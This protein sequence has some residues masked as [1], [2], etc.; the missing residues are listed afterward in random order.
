MYL[1]NKHITEFWPEI[2]LIL[3]PSPGNVT[4]PIFFIKHCSLKLTGLGVMNLPFTNLML[5]NLVG[6][7][8]QLSHLDLEV[9]HTYILVS[10]T[11]IAKHIGAQSIEFLILF[12]NKSFCRA[13]W[14]LLRHLGQFFSLKTWFNCLCLEVFRSAIIDSWHSGPIYQK[15][16][17]FTSLTWIVDLKIFCQPGI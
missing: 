12:P 4:T 10:M 7:C 15:S 17:G 2:Y 14:W 8:S 1:I 6:R 13:L 16:I 9:I 11:Q 3:Y 5:S